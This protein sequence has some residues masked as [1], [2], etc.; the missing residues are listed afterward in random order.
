MGTKESDSP[1][2]IL[3]PFLPIHGGG[4]GELQG[5]WFI[6]VDAGFAQSVPGRSAR[7]PSFL[8]LPGLGL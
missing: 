8:P 1:A 6:S 4:S 2:P 5:R 3:L 7:A